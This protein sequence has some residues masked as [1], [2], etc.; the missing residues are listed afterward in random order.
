M[1]NIYLIRH[2]FT[3]ANNA[4]YNGQRDLRKIAVDS[5]MPLEKTFGRRQAKELGDYLNFL[6]G[7]TLILVSP[8]KRCIETMDI[9][10][11]RLSLNY[12]S[13]NVEIRIMDDLHE[14]DSGI[15]YARTKEE[16]LEVCPKARLFYLLKKI[17]SWDLPYIE[18][19][20]EHDV[21]Q[22]VQKVG[23]MLKKMGDEDLYDNILVF[24]H[25]SVN[26]WL[27]YWINNKVFNTKIKNCEV[28]KGNGK[29]AGRSLFIPEVYVPSGYMIDINDYIN[30]VNKKRLTDK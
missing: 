5:E 25:G 9:A 10:L 28:I 29:D 30:D 15:H 14:I 1:S 21:G 6:A 11:S 18:G 7:K 12:V 24:G 13:N 20:S 23:L 27:Y 8:Y 2:G 22:R 17:G 19:E 4:N 26:R 3:P 16:V